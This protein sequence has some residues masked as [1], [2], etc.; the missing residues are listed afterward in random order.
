[1]SHVTPVRFTHV[2]AA[3]HFFQSIMDTGFAV[4]TDHLIDPQLTADVYAEWKQ[5]F[6]SEDK[7]QYTYDKSVQAGY[8]PFGSEN[9]KGAMYSDLKE[10]FRYYAWWDRNP[11]SLMPSTLRYFAQATEMAS[12][13]LQWI[14]K[15]TPDDIRASFSCS[16]P[17]MAEA[18]SETLLQATHYPPL[19]G[20]ENTEAVRAAAHE[21]IN[22]LTLLP[23]ATASGLE[24]QDLKGHWHSISCDP[25]NMIINTGDMLKEA[26]GGYYPSTTHRVINPTGEL[27]LQSRYSLPLFVHA[28]SEVRISQRYTAY[29]YWKERMRENGLM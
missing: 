15:Y 19:T 20:N 26:S 11:L 1:M 18:S 2:N 8:F 3:E 22:L 5:F 4:L 27:A 7:H 17:K 24:V 23:G 28:R 12:I 9:A 25:G 6:A 16:L 29:E 10:F 14:E 21:D 13:L